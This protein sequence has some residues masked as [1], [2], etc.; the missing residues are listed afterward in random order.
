METWKL[1]Y[2]MERRYL[3][4]RT[5]NPF[6]VVVLSEHVKALR[7]NILEGKTSRVWRRIT[8]SETAISGIVSVPVMLIYTG[9]LQPRST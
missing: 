9:A 1:K 5:Y 6:V 8:V 2:M 4:E 7:V 3:I